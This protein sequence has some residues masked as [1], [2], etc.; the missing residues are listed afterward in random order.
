MGAL[1][2]FLVLGLVV[3]WL[4]Y[5]PAVRGLLKPGARRGKPQRPP[6]TPSPPAAT[7]PGRIVPCAHC[8]VHLPLSDAL[9]DVSGHTYCS[10][11]HRQAGPRP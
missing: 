5:S 10:E 4:L 7:P 3:V 6:A 8:G 1:L 11:A 2:K 9:H